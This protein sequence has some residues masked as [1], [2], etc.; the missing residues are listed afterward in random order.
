MR[1]AIEMAAQSDPDVPI[2]GEAVATAQ[3][4]PVRFLENILAE[5]R[6]AGLI[7]SRRGIDGGYW[8]AKP[9]AE[10]SVADVIRAVE[11]PLASVRGEPASELQYEGSAKPLQDV[12]LA[13]QANVRAVLE[14]TT[15]ADITSAELPD[16]VAWL[17]AAARAG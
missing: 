5:L 13:L 16:E 1:A 6:Q 10:I 11:G 2:K 17:S 7:H 14:Q 12:W 8:L 9:A 3:K 15:L 4:I